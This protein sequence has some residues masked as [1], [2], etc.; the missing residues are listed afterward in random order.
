MAKRLRDLRSRLHN[1]FEPLLGEIQPKK[2]SCRKYV[3]LDEATVLVNSGM[4]QWI[5]IEWIETARKIEIC[6]VCLNDDGLKRSCRNCL[7]GF[8]HTPVLHPKYHDRDI[9]ITSTAS[10]DEKNGKKIYRSAHALKTPRV[11]TIEAAH[12]WRAYIKG[13]K[14]EIARIEA[15]GELGQEFIQSLI[16]PFKPDPFEGRILFT[17]YNDQRTRGGHRD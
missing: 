9:V 7:K 4:A 1:C 15:Y 5:V 3:S 8:T 2:C 16:V 14:D 12:L 17:F 6:N 11:A 13:D 10:I